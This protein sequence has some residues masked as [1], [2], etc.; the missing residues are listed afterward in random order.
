MPFCWTLAIYKCISPNQFLPMSLDGVL[1]PM[2]VE[3]ARLELGLISTHKGPVHTLSELRDAA[4]N[5]IQ[6]WFITAMFWYWNF[7]LKVLLT[8]SVHILITYRQFSVL[9]F[10]LNNSLTLLKLFKSIQKV[11][12]ISLLCSFTPISPRQRFTN[13]F[14][15]GSRLQHLLKFVIEVLVMSC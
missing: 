5:C 11:L 7:L 13:E 12:I 15:H 6:V 9:S 4:K 8:I 3:K 14:T 10:E 2:I 1:Y